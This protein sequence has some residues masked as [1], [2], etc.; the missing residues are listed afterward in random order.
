MVE[1]EAEAQAVAA[2]VGDHVALQQLVINHSGRRGAEGQE[3]A[4]VRRRDRHHQLAGVERREPEGR[5]TLDEAPLQ[6]VDV[7]VNVA[8]AQAQAVQPVEHRVQA[9]QADRIEGR[10][11]EAPAVLGVADAPALALLQRAEGGVPAGIARPRGVTRRGVQEGHALA[12]HGVLVAAGHVEGAGLQGLEVRGQGQEAVI[13]VDHHQRLVAGHRG[14]EG[15]RVGHGVA[16]IVE[17]LAEVDEVVP[18]ARGGLGEARRKVR[19][20]LDRD[21]FDARQRRLLEP[22][23]LAREA[24][25]L[26]VGAEHRDR[27]PGGQGGEQAVQQA[28]SVGREGDVLGPAQVQDP[29]HAPLRARVHFGEDQVPLA[30]GQA[31][32][33][34]PAARL[35]LEG[36]VRPKVVTVRGEMQPPRLRLQEPPKMRLIAQAPPS[37]SLRAPPCAPPCA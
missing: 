16:R 3:M 1:A 19:D 14:N 22:A 28:V 24:V 4:A 37:A 10:A 31:R 33:V 5:E 36:H 6:G 18:A 13:A 34:E 7:G 11:Q 35:R 29:R 30:V 21:P 26:A 15:R 9:V 12:G 25:E 17:H 27:P 32:R 2:V 23:H 8:H 20:R